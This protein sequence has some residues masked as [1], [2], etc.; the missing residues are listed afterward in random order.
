MNEPL[1]KSLPVLLQVRTKCLDLFNRYSPSAG[2]KQVFFSM[3][4][5]SVVPQPG[6][7]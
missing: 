4:I 6:L 5:R 3:L 1:L 7:M 2:I